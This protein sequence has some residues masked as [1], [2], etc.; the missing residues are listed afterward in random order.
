MVLLKIDAFPNSQSLRV[1]FSPN[2]RSLCV[3]KDERISSLPSPIE[4]FNLHLVLSVAGNLFCCLATI[5]TMCEFS[6][7][8]Y[9]LYSRFFCSFV[10]CL[11][12][13]VNMILKSLLRKYE[14]WNPVHPTCGTFWGTGVAVGCGVGWGPGYGPEVIGYVGAG[15]GAGFNVGI[16]LLGVGIGLPANYRFTVPHSGMYIF[17]KT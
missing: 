4:V 9:E 12:F 7:N 15:Y 2:V 1:L 11:N 17:L 8:F 16:T 13:E 10:L 14:R 5:V 3:M 6:R